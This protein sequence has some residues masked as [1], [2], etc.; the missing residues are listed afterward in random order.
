M[1]SLKTLRTPEEKELL[2]LIPETGSGFSLFSPDLVAHRSFVV[3]L[4]DEVKVVGIAQL[5]EISS[6]VDNAIGIGFIETHVDFRNQG[7]SKHLVNSVFALAQSLGKDVANTSYEPDGERWLKHTMHAYASAY[8]NV[9]LIERD[10]PTKS[11]S[12]RW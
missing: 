4:S 6:R 1:I 12:P 10:E 11:P 7:I 9:R 8:P 5:V 2:R 3:A